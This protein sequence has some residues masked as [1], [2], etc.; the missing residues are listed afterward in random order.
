MFVVLLR[1]FSHF[2]VVG[3]RGTN[4]S[5]MQLGAGVLSASCVRRVPGY[6]RPLDGSGS[7]PGPVLT[8]AHCL[9]RS[10]YDVPLFILQEFC[11]RPAS[12]ILGGLHKQVRQL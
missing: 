10:A 6:R 4:S 1:A 11:Y 7:I 9:C 8:S 5:K 3:V 12:P 2:V